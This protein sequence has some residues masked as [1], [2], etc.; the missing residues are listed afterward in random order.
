MI[1]GLP[2][3]V[4]VV[5]NRL[6]TTSQGT[7]A[8]GGNDM[9]A[10]CWVLSGG[11]SRGESCSGADVAL[12][13]LCRGFGEAEVQIDWLQETCYVLGRRLLVASAP[14]GIPSAMELDG[15]AQ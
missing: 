13:I 5:G 11:A 10:V 1:V 6:F 9:T 4:R 2:N 15:R 7:R 8:A 3:P 14:T 12:L